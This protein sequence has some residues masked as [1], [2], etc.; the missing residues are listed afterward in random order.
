MTTARTII[1][2]ALKKINVLGAGSPLSAADA[3][4]A[5]ITL[6][7]MMDSWSVEGGIV[8]TQTRESF[9]LTNAKQ[10]SIGP[11]G[12]F[13]TTRPFQ[14]EAA[15]V[16][17]GDTDYNLNQIDQRG[18]ASII[19]KD[20]G[21]IPT[22]FYYDNNSPI[23]NIFLYPAPDPSYELHLYSTKV[24]ERFDNLSDDITLPPGFARALIYNLAVE[25]ASDYEREPTG[26]TKEIADMSKGAVFA[27]NTRNDYE[28]AGVDDALLQGRSFN[29]YG[30][31][32]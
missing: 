17:V 23:G 14:I 4:D 2:Q 16:R 3:Q 10:Y 22:N 25:M 29:I 31:E 19:Y 7:N 28:V 20:N 26:S 1:E 13:D 15:F 12:D 5:L 6:N 9:P 32:Q 8:F 27:Y 11:G 21:G 30:G 24:L 18:Y